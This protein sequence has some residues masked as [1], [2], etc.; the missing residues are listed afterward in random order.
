MT[1]DLPVASPVLIHGDDDE[2]VHFGFTRQQLKTAFAQVCD[3]ANWKN[4]I[5]SVIDLA[6]VQVTMAA[7][8]FYTASLASVELLPDGRCSVKA[9][10]Y[11]AACGA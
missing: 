8:S 3:M 7:I 2:I 9:A 5:A 10:G 11:Y 4:P 6:N 1:V